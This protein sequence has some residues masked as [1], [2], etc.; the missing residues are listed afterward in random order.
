MEWPLSYYIRP[1]TALLL[2][3]SPPFFC[4]S[5]GYLRLKA[6]QGK[7][8]AYK[9]TRI[10]WNKSKQLYLRECDL[11]HWKSVIRFSKCNPHNL[12]PN[13]QPYLYD[14]MERV[15]QLKHFST[16]TKESNSV[17]VLGQS[18][19][20]WKTQLEAVM[21]QNHGS[22]AI[23]SSYLFAQE[24]NLNIALTQTHDTKATAS[25]KTSLSH[26]NTTG[27]QPLL[28]SLLCIRSF[29]PCT[30]FFSCTQFYVCWRSLSVMF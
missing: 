13:F 6:L 17:L 23:T 24:K 8:N 1:V 22:F 16:A 7:D 19:S 2:A 29:P 30:R 14:D 12:F 9:I 28:F 15:L 27:V 26:A 18:N 11:S 20:S 21:H 3:C 10:Q 25:W 5:T 4:Q